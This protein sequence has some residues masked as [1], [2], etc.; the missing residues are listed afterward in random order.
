MLQL[1]TIMY[2]MSP[3]CECGCSLNKSSGYIVA[4]SSTYCPSERIWFV[5]VPDGLVIRLTFIRFDI[6][7]GTVRVHDGNSSLSN[8]LL[9]IEPESTV[10]PQSLLSA[11]NMLRVEY[12]LQHDELM[13]N[14]VSDGGFI[15]F[16]LS[17]STYMPCSI[18]LFQISQA[19][20][21]INKVNGKTGITALRCLNMN[22]P[23]C[24]ARTVF[25]SVLIGLL[26]SEVTPW[27]MCF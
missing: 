26:S 18:F 27:N 24:W 5:R 14:D 2:T 19:A 17:E 7:R 9:Q 10:M 22:I 20:T 12:V 4:L 6:Q 15:A 8:L 25:D 16:V 23:L 3:N 11:G 1:S 13:D 21:M